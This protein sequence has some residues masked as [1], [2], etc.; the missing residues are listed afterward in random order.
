MKIHYCI[1]IY[2]IASMDIS[3]KRNIL[4]FERL[5]HI[6]YISITLTWKSTFGTHPLSRLSWLWH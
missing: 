5:S 2:F 6:V 1:L 4:R 3:I